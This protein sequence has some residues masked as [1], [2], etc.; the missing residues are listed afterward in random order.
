MPYLHVYLAP[1]GQWS[2]KVL[3]EVAGIAGCEC[4]RD[5]LLAAR[6]QFPDTED[7]STSPAGLREDGEPLTDIEAI[8]Y[9]PDLAHPGNG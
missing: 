6:E 3:E 5:V 9:P 1:S 4:P 2:G 8:G 7:L